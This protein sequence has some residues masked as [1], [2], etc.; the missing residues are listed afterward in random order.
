MVV[1][2]GGQAGGWIIKTLRSEGFDGPILLISAEKHPPYERPPLSKNLLR[3]ADAISET[4]LLSQTDLE[5]AGVSTWLGDPVID[6][7]RSTRTVRC[8]SGREASYHRLFLTTGSEPRI[9]DWMSASRSERIHMLR[10]IDDAS[11]LRAALASTAHLLIV[12]GGWIGL[13]VAA[14]VRG[15]GVAATVIESAPRLCQR[16][17]PEPF[18]HWLRALHERHGVSFV[19]GKTVENVID[20]EH[21][22][23]VLLDD[24]SSCIADRLLVCVGAVPHI[25]L[26]ERAGL[27]VGNGIV[28]DESGRTS[29]PNIYAA[30]DVANFPCSFAGCATR[31]ESW[32]NAQNQAIAVAKAALGQTICYSDLP[33]LW[34]DQYHHNIQ[35]AG[36]PERADKVVFTA[37]T[38]PLSGVWLSIDAEHQP[39]GAIGVDAPKAFRPVMKSLKNRNSIDVTGWESLDL[40]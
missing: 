8:A 4:A 1:V 18:S 13:E 24:G 3:S 25:A 9:P 20:G 34:S 33:W 11:A 39:C 2:G 37:G 27:D 16:S 38:E 30:G 5:R 28:V 10:T 12:G 35:I 17:V 32:A 14:S 21:H 15:L 40:R 26:A 31:R 23:G 7:D 29:D 19:M 6:I 36:L 22:V